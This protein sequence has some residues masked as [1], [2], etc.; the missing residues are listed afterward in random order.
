MKRT[1]KFSMNRVGRL[2]K[3]LAVSLAGISLATSPLIQAADQA[4][5][6]IIAQLPSGMSFNNLEKS[7]LVEAVHRA[8][9]A[10]PELA[11]EIAKA[12][13]RARLALVSR[14][15]S[16]FLTDGE[17]LPIAQ[18]D[19]TSQTALEQEIIDI[20]LAV[21]AGATPPGE[22][23]DPAL[24]NAVLNAVA[25]IIPPE[26]TGLYN[27]VVEGVL[28]ALPAEVSNAV[29]KLT[30]VVDNYSVP[31]SG[32]GTS[33]NYFEEI[34]KKLNNLQSEGGDSESGGGGGSGGPAPTP[35]DD[36]QVTPFTNT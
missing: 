8:A 1:R 17:L 10:N 23:P 5:Q 36:G 9:S 14:G 15:T 35:P 2:S 29:A 11:P 20:I 28:A 13:V 26:F 32:V 3:I 19:T 21:I 27:N 18:G 22:A 34:Q 4:E 12:A 7:A 33:N 24:V 25:T 16:M 6:L 30:N 31:P